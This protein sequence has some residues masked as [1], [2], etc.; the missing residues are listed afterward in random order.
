[1]ILVLENNYK[2][3]VPL[4]GAAMLTLVN[5]NAKGSHMTLRV[6]KWNPQAPRTMADLL[7]PKEV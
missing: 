3:L 1:M 2:I 5:G 6:F 4:F 7:Q